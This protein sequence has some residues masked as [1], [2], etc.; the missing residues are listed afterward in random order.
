M[1]DVLDTLTKEKLAEFL[2]REANPTG[3]GQPYL[4]IKQP[5]FPQYRF[6]WHPQTRKVYLARMNVKPVVGEIIAEHVETHGHAF[7]A[8][9]TWL[10]GYHE[11]RAPD[12]AKPHLEG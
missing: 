2:G 10:R 6:E 4:H 11:G 5:N 8:V 12:I 3:A 1:V 9:Q 7:G